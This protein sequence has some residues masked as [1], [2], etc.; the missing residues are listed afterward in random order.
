MLGMLEINS[1]T[2]Q[3]IE[4]QFR[5]TCTKF[6][7]TADGVTNTRATGN[8]SIHEFSKKRTITEFHLLFKVCAAEPS[9]AQLEVSKT[10]AIES[11][12]I[13]ERGLS[14]MGR[15]KPSFHPCKVIT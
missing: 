7:K 10:F 9:T 2:L 14:G 4:M 11:S 8:I 6:A 3:E 15:L 5:R 12:G 1:N 13:G